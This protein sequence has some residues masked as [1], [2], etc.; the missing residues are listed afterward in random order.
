MSIRNLRT[1]TSFKNPV[2]VLYFGGML[3]EMAAMNMQMIARSLLVYRL[4]E[5]A[6]ILGSMGLA[7]A[8]PMILVALFGGVLADRFQKK[9]VLLFGQIGMAILSLGIALTITLGYLSPEREGSWWILIGAGA[10]QGAIMGIAMPSRQ[11]IIPEIKLKSWWNGWMM[12][13]SESSYPKI[14][15]PM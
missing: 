7:S 9:Y 5:S 11:A 2:Y 13:M 6:S 14:K 15:P 8:V 10:V 4:T 3:G 1:F 12:K